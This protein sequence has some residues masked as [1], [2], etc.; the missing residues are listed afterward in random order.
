MRTGVGLTDRAALSLWDHELFASLQLLTDDLLTDHPAV[1][2]YTKP[3]RLWLPNLIFG[4]I[5]ITVFTVFRVLCSKMKKRTDIR[6]F[7]SVIIHKYY[8]LI[9]H[10]K[11]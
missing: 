3:A 9:N 1:V 2:T 6:I 8:I 10:I 11:K 7:I 5:L 4:I